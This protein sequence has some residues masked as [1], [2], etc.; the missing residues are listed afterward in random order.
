MSTPKYKIVRQETL[1]KTV[2]W[3]IVQVHIDDAESFVKRYATRKAAETALAR[4][5]ERPEFPK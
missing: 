5:E 4:W 1:G 2:Y 3:D